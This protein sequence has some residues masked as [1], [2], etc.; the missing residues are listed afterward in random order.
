MKLYRVAVRWCNYQYESNGIKKERFFFSNENACKHI[1]QLRKEMKSGF[2]NG[3]QAFEDDEYY[4]E[5][6]HHTT[7]QSA[8]MWST[9]EELEKDYCK[10]EIEEMERTL[11]HPHFILLHDGGGFSYSVAIEPEEIEVED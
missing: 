11:E 5:D 1:E 7:L 3:E 10:E 4:Y 8:L 2:I 6:E 9:M